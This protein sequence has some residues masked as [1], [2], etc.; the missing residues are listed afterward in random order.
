MGAA[1]VGGCTMLSSYVNAVFRSV[2]AA[3]LAAAAISCGGSPGM[4]SQPSQPLS[5]TGSWMGTGTDSG[6]ATVVTW[7]LTQSGANVSGTVATQAVNPNDGSCNSCHRNKTGTV[8]GTLSGTTLNL[9][10]FF[11]A[12][13]NG[14]PTPACSASLSG[15]AS[16]VTRSSLTAGYSG[17]DTCEGPL[18]S[19]TLV[20][21]H[22]P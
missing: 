12:G 11:A 4:P 1:H 19:G 17:S 7:T 6:G 14:D 18:T 16:S 2:S 5:L 9:E 15:T 8:S 3:A 20:L 13:V 21:A 22:S 10:M